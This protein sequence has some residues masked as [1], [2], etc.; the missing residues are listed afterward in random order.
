MKKFLYSIVMGLFALNAAPALSVDTPAVSGPEFEKANKIYF[1]D[2]AGCHG[3]DRNGGM[4]PSLFPEKTR[5][6]MGTAKVEKLLDEGTEHGMPAFGKKKLL[7]PEE[8][9]LMARYIQHDPN[10]NPPGMS[11]AEIKATWKVHVPVKDRPAKA[12]NANADNLFGVVLRDWGKVAV[13][14]G[15][16]KAKIVEI[17]GLLGTHFLRVSK[18]GHYLYAIQRNG[19]ISAID[20]WMKEPKVV[21]KVDVCIES[22]SAETSKAKGFEDKYIMVGCRWP[23]N[24]IILDGQTLEPK[25]VISATDSKGFKP[26][27]GVSGIGASHS[28]PQWAVNMKETGETWLVDYSNVAN[29]NITKIESVRNPLDGG[30][31]KTKRYFMVVGGE[32]QNTV[33]VI[34]TKDKKKAAS[35]EISSKFAH[36][37]RPANW[38]HPKYGPV[39]A[40][41]HLGE[42]KFSIWGSD[43]EGHPDHAWKV[44]ETVDF[45][46]MLKGNKTLKGIEKGGMFSIKTH[47]NSK[48]I[49]V[50]FLKSSKKKVRQTVCVFNKEDIT[51]K[52]QCARLTKKGKIFHIEYNKAG[53]EVWVSVMHNEGQIIVFDDAAPKLKIKKRIKGLQTPT[54]KFNIYN[55]MNDIY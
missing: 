31:D 46:P 13:I 55:R 15:A 38:D 1:R 5:D 10:P 42:A 32:N 40:A 9:N 6:D 29:P 3:T 16:S 30:W 25:K 52:P 28:A 23:A 18:S 33:A 49:W 47:P 37:I 36:P 51:A 44:V 45:G 26:E 4:G 27:L 7:T 19:T 41:L 34:C 14:D 11:E 17:E 21:A 8:L 24:L 2:C 22:Q 20:L 53:D 50:D 39:S 12:E 43:P 35:F 54:G 48:H